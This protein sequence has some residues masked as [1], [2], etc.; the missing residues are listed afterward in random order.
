MSV[1]AFQITSSDSQRRA[2]AE[3]KEDLR[4]PR[5]IKP[6]EL[7][8]RSRL[9]ASLEPTTS[10][11]PGCQHGSHRGCVCTTGDGAVVHV[12]LTCA[13]VVPRLRAQCRRCS[14]PSARPRPAAAATGDVV[15]FVH[16][17]I[18]GDKLVGP[19]RSLSRIVITLVASGGL[20]CAQKYGCQALLCRRW[21]PTFAASQGFSD[22][23]QDPWWL[24]PCV[25]NF[26]VRLHLSLSAIQ[27]PICTLS[28]SGGQD[29]GGTCPVDAPWKHVGHIFRPEQWTEVRYRS[30]RAWRV[31]CT[32]Y[33]PTGDLGTARSNTTPHRTLRNIRVPSRSTGAY[34]RLDLVLTDRRE[35]RA[36]PRILVP[37]IGLC[38]QS[39]HGSR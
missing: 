30:R 21:R 33:S 8:A 39:R 11:R 20:G 29:I 13:H 7:T 35:S 3:I 6:L 23:F 14:V 26:C 18:N 9:R 19:R 37:F 32:T 38:S 4:D 12:R 27:L 25:A 36:R 24:A 28:V 1:A 16:G 31:S 2:P 5:P 22:H 10:R 34:K 15:A 17:L